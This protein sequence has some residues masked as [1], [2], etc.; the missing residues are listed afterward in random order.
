MC[1][2][3]RRPTLVFENVVFTRNEQGATT[4][5]S[6]MVYVKKRV[7]RLTMSVTFW[8]CEDYEHMDSC[9]YY[10]KDYTSNDICELMGKKNQI[11][12]PFMDN[13]SMPPRCPINVGNYTFA[14]TPINEKLLTILPLPNAF[15]KLQF[16]G[17]DTIT[18]EY[19][20]CVDVEFEIHS[21]RRN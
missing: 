18:G 2:G 19:V 14:P 1:P 5:I 7:E 15:W 17:N 3:Q 12:T 8:K 10:L 20:S 9:E 21:R 11:W 13:F 4:A 6:F 16:K